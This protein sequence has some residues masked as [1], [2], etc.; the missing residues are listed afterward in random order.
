MTLITNE[1][2]MLDGFKKTVL[3]FAADQRI[4]K[5]NGAFDSL[6]KKLFKIPYLSAGISYFGLAQV[7]PNGRRQYLSD[8]LPVFI[9]KNSGAQNLGDFSSTLRDELHKIVPSSVLGA[10]ASGFHIG[11]YNA[12]GIPEFWFLTNIGGMDDFRYKDLAPRYSDPSSDFLRRDAVKLGWDGTN[13]ASVA[14]VIQIYRNGDFRA[15]VAAWEKLDGML[16]QLLGFPDFRKPKTPDDL[17]KWVK[18]KLEVIAYFY[19]NFAD[20]EIISRPI[21]VFCLSRQLK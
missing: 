16:A 17:G 20:R 12:Q 2:H 9:R 18:F 21:D 19:K 15:H 5:L 8:W 1:I 7:F 4:S 11:G 3:V 14:S 6:R 13:P 10:N